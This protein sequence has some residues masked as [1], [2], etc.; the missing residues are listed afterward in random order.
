MNQSA[1]AAPTEAQ[2]ELP[3]G[4]SSVVK[5]LAGRCGMIALNCGTGILTARALKPVGRGEL[6]AMILWPVFLSQ[7]FTLGLPSSVL[8]ALR[9]GRMQGRTLVGT[10]MLI[11][12]ILS[13]LT[14]LTGVLILPHW[15]NHYPAEVVRLGQWF[16]LTTPMT[17]LLIIGRSALE[18]RGKFGTSSFALL[19][20]PLQVAFG[21]LLLL[22][23]H[24][25]TPL[26]AG[27][28]YVLSGFPPIVIVLIHLRGELL[29][30][31][32][33][34]SQ[35]A[36]EL[37]SY[38]LRSYGIDL[39]GSLSQYVDQALVVGMLSPAAMGSY[40]VALSLSRMMNVPF[41]SA[42]AVLFPKAMNRELQSS[43]ALSLRALVGSLAIA[44]PAATL[45]LFGG[46][47]A[48][49]LLYGREYAVAQGLLRILVLEALISGS[50]TVM[51]QI[52]MA[53][54]K[55]GTV[56]TL[57]AAGVATSIPLIAVLVPHWGAAGAGFALLLSALLR[58]ALL[59]GSFRRLLPRS[60]DSMWKLFINEARYMSGK[61]S[62]KFLHLVVPSRMKAA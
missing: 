12:L 8:Y 49:R 27:W 51:S 25:L 30:V 62:A 16:M 11:G 18:A 32:S 37:L 22:T 59:W 47:I 20:A 33:E 1:V 24:R 2:T 34:V 58:A 3:G 60:E 53:I 15:L 52:F 13:V 14:T 19:C 54:G 38:G 40:T 31:W 48:L 5:S 41:T 6:A 23:F 57:Q 35:A 43:F 46:G 44:V 9:R 10:S 28:A 39:C 61:Y 36:R 21:L 55:P 45:V 42:A 50:I 56:T 29:P 4:L 17:I 26:S 7:A